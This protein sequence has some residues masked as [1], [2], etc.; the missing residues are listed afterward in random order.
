MNKFICHTCE[1]DFIIE[2]N[3]GNKFP[4]CPK[5]KSNKN[6]AYKGNEVV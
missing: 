2:K 6:V 5:C 4:I 1:T 3:I